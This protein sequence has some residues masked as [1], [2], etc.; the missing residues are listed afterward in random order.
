MV[1]VLRERANERGWNGQSNAVI[2][3]LGKRLDGD[4]MEKYKYDRGTQIR[5]SFRHSS[6][7]R[8]PMR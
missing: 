4:L 3:R 7:A 2:S 6:V 1:E 8:Q 5:L